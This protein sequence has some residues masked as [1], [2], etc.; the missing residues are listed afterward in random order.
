VP[1]PHSEEESVTEDLVRCPR[2]GYYSR[3][4]DDHLLGPPSDD[5][6][7]QKMRY[8]TTSGV[9]VRSLPPPPPLQPGWGWRVGSDGGF[10]YLLAEEEE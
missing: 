5:R 1:A 3:S 7:G 4:P 8:C 9:V 6:S 10:A 2:C